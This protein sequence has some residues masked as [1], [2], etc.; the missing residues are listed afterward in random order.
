NLAKE[1]SAVEGRAKEF[2]VVESHAKEEW[3]EWTAIESSVCRFRGSVTVPGRRHRPKS[4]V[5][6]QELG[7]T[8]RLMEREI[9]EIFGD[10]NCEDGFSLAQPIRLLLEYTDERYEEKRYKRTD[11]GEWKIVKYHLGIGFPNLPY[12]IDGDVKLSQSA[13][14]LRYLG[15]KYG[16]GGKNAKEKA[17]IAMTE[18]AVRDLRL[19]LSKISYSQNYEEERPNYIPTFEIGME[20]ISNFL[21]SKIWLMGESIT[22]ADFSLYENLCAFHSFEPS[23]FDKHPNLKQYVERFEALPKIKAYMDSEQFIS[24]PLNGWSANFG[25]G[26][27]PPQ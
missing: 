2:G 15:E 24:W 18:A 26:D 9:D 7:D 25:G 22:Y 21:G 14:I 16:L 10:D 13:V 3:A 23:C 19:G 6:L 5:W 20:E 12:I 4:P 1:K 11:F 17:E 8:R 27:A